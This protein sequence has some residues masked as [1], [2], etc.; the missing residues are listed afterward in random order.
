MNP[1]S[2]N[3]SRP[4]SSASAVDVM[5]SSSVTLFARSRA[6]STCTCEHLQPLAPDRRRWRRRGPGAGGPGSSSRRSS[7][8]RSS[9]SVSDDS[10][11]FM[12]RL[13][14][15]SGWIMNGGLAQ[16]GSV[17]RDDVAMRSC[18]TCRASRRSVPRSKIISICESCGTDF[19]RITSRSGTPL[20][21]CSSG[22]GDELFDLGRGEPEGERLDLDLGRRELG[23][24]VDLR[25]RQLDDADEQQRRGQR[26][27]D[28]AEPQ[29]RSNDPAHHGRRCPRSVSTAPPK[30]C[31]VSTR[32]PSRPRTARRS[33]WS[34]PRCP[35]SGPSASTASSPAIVGTV[36]GL[37]IEG[38]GLRARV[39][40]GL[41]RRRRRRPPRTGRPWCP[42]RS[43]DR[44]GLDAE[45]FD[46]LVSVRRD[47][48]DLAAVAPRRA[49]RGP[50][51]PSRPRRVGAA[52]EREAR[53]PPAPRPAIG[54]GVCI[55]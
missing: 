5:T 37:R 38:A 48:L 32:S 8:C 36:I 11:I 19:D 24:D 3:C 50:S 23:E 40:P 17:G 27:H 54:S 42:P 41:A 6:G 12:T 7:T 43:V 52:G 22:H 15:E 13:V 16:V 9:T 33:R 47:L 25:V 31:V 29:A 39:H 35:A 45:P 44:R 49:R 1:P 28:E 10:P 51:A 14:A 21:D 20:S 26:D 4:A 18:T 2:E 53:R 30:V 34:R 55:A 46:R